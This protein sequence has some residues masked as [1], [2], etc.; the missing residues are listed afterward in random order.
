MCTSWMLSVCCDVYRLT[1]LDNRILSLRIAPRIISR[2]M[3][4][5]VMVM[6]AVDLLMASA[7]TFSSKSSPTG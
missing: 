7:P 1:G 3:L 6:L 5:G 2:R 4:V